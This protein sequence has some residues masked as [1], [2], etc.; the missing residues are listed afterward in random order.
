LVLRPPV[1]ITLVNVLY[2]REHAD[3]EPACS[4]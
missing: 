1:L 4:F 2:M 3:L